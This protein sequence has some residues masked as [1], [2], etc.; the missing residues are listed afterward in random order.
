MFPTIFSTELTKMLDG[1]FSC[2]P[3]CLRL[4]LAVVLLLWI[5]LL[6]DL[7]KLW[8]FWVLAGEAD[9]KQLGIVFCL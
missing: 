9:V 6:G 8:F 3:D 4:L 1:L 5:A 2:Y 7:L